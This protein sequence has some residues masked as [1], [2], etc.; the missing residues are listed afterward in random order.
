MPHLGITP[1]LN[2]GCDHTV[3]RFADWIG[4]FWP[5]ILLIPAL[6]VMQHDIRKGVAHSC[7][8]GSRFPDLWAATYPH[9]HAPR[10]ALAPWLSQRR[11]LPIVAAASRTR[12]STSPR[13]CR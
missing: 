1:W 2:Y 7:A 5:F 10:L 13:S 11:A 8:A 3:H 6:L 4:T 12:S 9:T